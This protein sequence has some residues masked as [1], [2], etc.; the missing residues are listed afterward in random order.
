MLTITIYSR[1]GISFLLFP[2]FYPNKKNRSQ[3]F[4]LIHA[5]LY[6]KCKIGPNRPDFG[7]TDSS[8]SCGANVS[9][10]LSVT[11][12]IG[13]IRDG[14]DGELIGTNGVASSTTGSELTSMNCTTFISLSGNTSGSSDGS[15]SSVEIEWIICRNAVAHCA[16]TFV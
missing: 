4:K 11:N 15:D 16:D 14:G 3:F 8:D 2:S 1:F 10:L 12:G 5:V 7:L 9:T 13:S 6:Y